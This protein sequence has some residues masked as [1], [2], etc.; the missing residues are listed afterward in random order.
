MVIVRCNVC[1]DESPL[2]E[3]QLVVSVAEMLT[4]MVAHE[5]HAGSD[6][7]LQTSGAGQS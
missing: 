6:I 5:D 3:D 1:G 2:N 4:F 7:E